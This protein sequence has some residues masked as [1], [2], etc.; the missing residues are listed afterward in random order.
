[1]THRQ[2]GESIQQ[3]VKQPQASRALGQ[4]SVLFLTAALF[5]SADLILQA[6][7]I[8]V[9]P[10]GVVMALAVIRRTVLFLYLLMMIALLIHLYRKKY[11]LTRASSQ[12]FFGCLTLWVLSPALTLVLQLLSAIAPV[13]SQYSPPWMTV[14]AA[15]QVVFTGMFVYVI[16]CLIQR[17]SLLLG[18][19]ALVLIYLFLSLLP[20]AIP[21][22]GSDG[23]QYLFRPSDVYQSVAFPV[24]YLLTG[25]QLKQAS[26]RS[27]K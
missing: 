14:I 7:A 27:T 12:I 13:P 3:P 1:M 10:S 11:F 26:Q 9:S 23:W 20:E 18:G 6:V 21:L 8:V 5:L 4:F 17:K 16:G 24:L 22:G 15:A 19:T 2:K 25:L